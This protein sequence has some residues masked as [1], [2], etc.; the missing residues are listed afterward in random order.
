VPFLVT[1][2]LA[3]T[4]VSALPLLVVSLTVAQLTFAVALAATEQEG[5]SAGAL[6]AVGGDARL[7]TTA[8][9]EVAETADRIAGEPGV[10]AAAS[11]RVADAVRASSEST[12]GSVRLVVVD[13]PAY[14]QLLARSDLPDAPALDRLTSGD[15]ERVPALLLG[16]DAGLRD[17]LV[18][19]WDDTNIPLDVVGRA[20][21]VDASVDPVVVVDAG[22][23][24]AAGAIAPPDTVWAV[25]PGAAS[26]LAQAASSSGSVVRYADMLDARR[27]A[28]LPEG[29]VRLAVAASALL[30]LLAVLGVVLSALT[31]APAR[32]A[33]LGRLRALGLR[34]GDLRRVLAGELLVPVAVAALAGLALGV[35]AAR[36]VVGSLDLERVTGQTGT[37]SL[38]VPWWTALVVVAL[39]VTALVV[40]AVEW[41]RLRR[42]VLAQLLRS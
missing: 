42:R 38:V 24:A 3:Q 21:R 13:A 25:G 15:G 5:Q 7:V 8:G 28:P 2:R 11:G 40:A 12:A 17:G 35:S 30:L 10:R 23:F 34:D 9:P 16:G 1:A 29:L 36:V 4:G 32:S 39:L 27:D 20:P 22:A 26:A 31:E 19:T 14:E 33:S 18:V 6:L 37:P 41:R